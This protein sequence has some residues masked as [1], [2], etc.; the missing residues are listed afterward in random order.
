MLIIAQ[1]FP[2]VKG[3][4]TG[5]GQRD[6]VGRV[7]GNGDAFS[8]AGLQIDYVSAVLHY[9]MPLDTAHFADKASGYN[10]LKRTGIVAFRCSVGIIPQPGGRAPKAIPWADGFV[11]LSADAT[12]SVMC[13]LNVIRLQLI[14]ACGLQQ[15]CAALRTQI[16]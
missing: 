15:T 4:A 7:M 16:P 13:H 1:F 2:F 10:G 9:V 14:G 3:F 11:D 5:N 12:L 6:S 8:T